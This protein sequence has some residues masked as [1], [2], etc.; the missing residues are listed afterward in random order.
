MRTAIVSTYP[1]RACGIG[2]FAADLRATLAGTGGIRV[3]LVAVVHEPSSPQ[4][5]GVLATIAQAVRGDYIRTARMLGRLD[6][7]VVLLQHEYGIFGGRDG[8]YVLSFARELAQPLVVTLH[9]VLSEPTPHQ[10]EVLT[11]LCGEA[12]LVIVMTETAR[13]LLVDSGT[14]PEEK[15]RIVPHGA[16]ARITARAEREREERPPR[17]SDGDTFRLSTFG[18]ISPGKGLETVIEALPAM[19]ERYPEITYTIAGRTHPDI[20]RREGERYRLILERRVL[21]LGL[22]DHV[23]FD[24]RFLTVDELSDL[25]ATT[26]VFLTPY[27]NREQ[28]ASGALTFAIAAGCAVV[29]TPYW[30]A[31]DMLASG[32]G[33]LVPFRDPEAL[34]NAVCSYLERPDALAAARAEA[35]R[36]GSSLAWPAV[37][38][39]TAAVLHEADDLAPR[40]RPTGV[41]DLH[42]TS[43]RSDHLLTLADDVGIVQHAHGIIPNRDSGYCVDDVA[44]LAVVS[45][46]LARRGDEQVWTSHLYRSLAFLHAA[47]AGGGMRNFMSYDRRWLDEPHV[48]DHVGRSI[49]ALG[50]ILATAWIPA[51]VRPAADLLDQ[52]VATLSGEVYL[53]TAA[54]AVLGL[55]RLDAD[56]LDPAAKDLLV[57]LV[58]QLAEAYEHTATADWRWFEDEL[59]YDNARLSQ[60]LLTGANALDRPE[61]AELGLDSL[62]WLGDECGLGGTVL[63]LPGHQGRRRG[64]PAPGEGDEQPL[65]AAALVEAELSAFAVTRE[66]EHGIR[67][68]RAFEWF[69]GRN[70]LQRPLY[71]FATGGCSDGLGRDTLNDNQGAES[72]LAFHHAALLLDAAG[73]RAGARE[74]AP[75][76]VPA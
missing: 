39:A 60:A 70:R 63:R 31:Q 75:T 74:H 27:G 44:R 36:I 22:E 41:A 35:Q 71:D 57:R 5:R 48:G 30:Y 21:E 6:V 54:Y 23:E 67:A 24:D 11:E 17:L 20:A 33:L 50:D 52:L 73:I 76:P 58:D 66:S 29:S 64:E 16:P 40:R 68:I 43:L 38:E 10:A 72:T 45:L 26:D 9:T 34:A 7:D 56:R 46:A 59:S 3:D 42:L 18:L 25:L 1:P 15:V 37:A 13:R 53:R 62:R 19:I 28:I 61:L 51:V 8:E 47:A 49:W 14:C 12:E 2:T 69:L 32:A 4:R 65:D 55:S